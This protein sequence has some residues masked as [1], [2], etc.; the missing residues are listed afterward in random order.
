MPLELAGL[1]DRHGLTEVQIDRLRC[2]AE[3]VVSD[4]SAPT[5]VR[6]PDKVV[7]DHIADSL[8][9]LD[10]PALAAPG[11]LVDIGAGAG[12]PGLVLA[13]ARRATSVS[14]LEAS[15]RKCAFIERAAAHCGLRNVE[16]VHARA[17]DWPE[18][19]GRFD[20]ATARALAPLAVV[21]EYAAPLLRPG[22][23]VVAWRGRRDLLAEAGAESAAAELGLELGEIRRVEPYPGAA[24]RHLHAA[25]KVAPTPQEFP[26]RPGVARKRPLGAR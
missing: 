21:F 3:L 8:V 19:L 24:H 14:L 26:R 25:R 15:A 1:A 9:A 6:E 2:L 4:P 23:S 17:E 16:V 13:V 22:G 5:A 11:R 12:F 10:L 7:E 20:V 18:G